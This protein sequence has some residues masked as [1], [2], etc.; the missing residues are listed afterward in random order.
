[1][2]LVRSLLGEVLSAWNR[3]GDW[4]VRPFR[5]RLW[6]PIVERL[7]VLAQAGIL[8]WACWVA[9]TRRTSL[10]GVPAAIVTITGFALLTFT[11]GCVVLTRHWRSVDADDEPDSEPPT[12]IRKILRRAGLVAFQLV[13]LLILVQITGKGHDIWQRVQADRHWWA[14]FFF[15]L[16]MVI[17]FLRASDRFGRWR[18]EREARHEADRKARELDR[19]AELCR[20]LLAA[21]APL[22]IADRL[23]PEALGSILG[24]QVGEAFPPELDAAGSV[25]EALLNDPQAVRLEIPM[26]SV[27]LLRT[28][29]ARRGLGVAYH[30]RKYPL[31]FADDDAGERTPDP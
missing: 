22:A 2:E 4:Y 29:E 7:A 19:K 15:P 24:I 17:P 8:V 23:S 11:A 12:G 6:G 26:N 3:A 14:W 16:L 30:D 13:P 5:A 27:Q 10:T 28:F 18:I 20:P 25:I 31:R 1:M 21:A 9:V